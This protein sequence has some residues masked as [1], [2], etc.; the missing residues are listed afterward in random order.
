MPEVDIVK[1]KVRRGT[2]SQ[3][4]ITILEQG[5]LGY[6][7]DYS[8][9]W[10]GDGITAGGNII[11]NKVYDSNQPRTSISTATK[12]DVVYENGKL[13]RL[14]S[15]TPITEADWEFIGTKIDPVFINI[16]LKTNLPLKMV[17]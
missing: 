12:G 14:T 7:T 6:T 11:G 3:R 1:L 5:E 9:L 2:D 17:V 13:Y 4:S 10:V 16:I 8:R 15:T